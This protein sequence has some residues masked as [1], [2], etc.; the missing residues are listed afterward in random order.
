MI[1]QNLIVFLFHEASD[2]CTIMPQL[3]Y[4]NFMSTR[5]LLLHDITDNTEKEMFALEKIRGK[6]E[7]NLVIICA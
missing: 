1:F 6:R 5:N 3:E 4:F 7:L 2:N